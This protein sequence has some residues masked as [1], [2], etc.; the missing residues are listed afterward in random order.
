MSVSPEKTSIKDQSPE[1]CLLGFE[2]PVFFVMIP[3][4]LPGRRHHKQ[5][6]LSGLYLQLK[7]FAEVAVKSREEFSQPLFLQRF[8]GDM[9]LHIGQKYPK[10]ENCPVAAMLHYRDSFWGRRTASGV[11]LYLW[12]RWS[13]VCNR[14]FPAGIAGMIEGFHGVRFCGSGS[15]QNI[16][17]P[18]K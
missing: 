1:A 16:K 17:N 4:H 14:N 3:A 7:Q 12:S 2:N 10:T 15:A 6:E 13:I 9:S 11:C 8:V 18:V 5:P